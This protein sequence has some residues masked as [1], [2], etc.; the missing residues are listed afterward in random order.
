MIIRISDYQN[1]L[2]D[3]DGV[4]LDSNLVKTKS[5]EEV[6]RNEK[7]LH[8]DQFIKY[9]LSNTGI[10]RYE[11]FDYYFKNIKYLDNYKN[12]LEIILFEFSKTVKSHLISC[13]LTHEIELI[14]RKIRKFNKNLFVISASDEKELN[15]ILHIRKLNSYFKKI[16]GSPLNKIENISK[17]NI[18]KENDKTIFFGDSLS[19]YK[20]AKYFNFDFV[21][22]KK[23]SLWKVPEKIKKS[24]KFNE[25]EDFSYLEIVA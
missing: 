6:L 1:F 20:A 15:E 16:L 3:C 2:F 25:I 8:K 7:K 13:K 4:I 14:L 19:D 22:I 11:K 12:E 10:S 5:F 24:Q 18:L 21:Y 17:L 23:Y 9:H